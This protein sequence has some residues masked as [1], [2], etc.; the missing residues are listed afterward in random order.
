MKPSAAAPKP[1][2]PSQIKLV[3][4]LLEL[5]QLAPKETAAKFDRLAQGKTFSEA[6]QEAIEI[7]FA[8]EE[9]EI[10]DAL[11]DFA[12]DEARDIVRDGL[13]HEARLTFVRA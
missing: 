10:P 9:D 7:L 3:L 2:T 11:F 12:D 5:R 1:L 6:Q 13:A 8:L 4:E